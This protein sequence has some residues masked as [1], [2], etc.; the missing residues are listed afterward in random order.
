MRAIV[1]SRKAPDTSR[2]FDCPGIS[3]MHLV[4]TTKTPFEDVVELLLA[5]DLD[6]TAVE[7]IDAVSTR[8]LVGGGVRLL[9]LDFTEV[10]FIDGSGL[11]ALE[12]VYVRARAEGAAM[13]LVGANRTIQK[14]FEI[15]GSPLMSLLSD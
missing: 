3:R 11:H 12:R 7:K 13:M 4:V 6:M 9:V 2:G 15:C 5:G 8:A 1:E 14:V 10:H